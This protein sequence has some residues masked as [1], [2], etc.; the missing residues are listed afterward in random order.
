[1]G[2]LGVALGLSFCSD[3][4]FPFQPIFGIE[5]QLLDL[6]ILSWVFPKKNM[7]QEIEKRYAHRLTNR[8][9]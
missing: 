5:T 4:S 9:I 1:M 3:E 2:A 7:T 6:K 8:D